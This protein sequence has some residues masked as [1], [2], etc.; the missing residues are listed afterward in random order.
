MIGLSSRSGAVRGG[1]V[2]SIVRA[3]ITTTPVTAQVGAGVSGIVR[4]PYSQVQF[5]RCKARG[6]ES[7]SL[8]KKSNL[9]G[10]STWRTS[11]LVWSVQPNSSG[12]VSRRTWSYRDGGPDGTNIFGCH[13]VSASS[14]PSSVR[15]RGPTTPWSGPGGAYPSGSA[16]RGRRSDST[17]AAHPGAVTADRTS[18]HSSQPIPAV[19]T[20]RRRVPPRASA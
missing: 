9:G 1:R 6:A 2:L 10:M 18:P 7:C 3:T 13:L 19:W 8:L 5:G 15:A 11:S 14:P 4:H 17:L 16:Q 12:P 20:I